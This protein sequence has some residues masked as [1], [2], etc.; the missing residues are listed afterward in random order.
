MVAAAASDDDLAPG[1]DRQ[2]ELAVPDG[3][4]AGFYALLG[5]VTNPVVTLAQ[6]G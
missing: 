6:V 1:G 5:S 3:A 4:V 2:V